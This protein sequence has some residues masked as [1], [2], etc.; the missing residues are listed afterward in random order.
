MP[1]KERNLHHPEL[2]T[3]IRFVGLKHNKP[4]LLI[5]MYMD[6]ALAEFVILRYYFLLRIFT[7]S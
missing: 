5:K 3:T 2:F 7:A 6:W 4:A 1:T